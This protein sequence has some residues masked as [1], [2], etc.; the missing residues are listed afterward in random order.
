MTESLGCRIELVSPADD[1]A[2]VVFSGHGGTIRVCRAATD[3]AGHLRLSSD[4]VPVGDRREPLVAPNGTVIELVSA[5]T[6]IVLPDNEPSLSIVRSSPDDAFGSGRAGM[7]YRDLLPDRW[8]GRFI[9]SHIR[10][11]EGGDVADYVHF[12][13]IRFQMIFVASGWVDV[14]YEDQGPPFRLHRGDCVLQ[15]PEIR[16]RV[17]RSSPGLE[18]IE[19]GC[20]ARHDTVA[21]HSIELP[22]PSA[23]TRPG[24]RWSTLRSPCCR[25]H[26]S[27]RCRDPGLHRSRHGH[28]TRD[29]SSGRRTGVGRGDRFG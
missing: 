29:G 2:E 11:A 17:L 15:P 13:R 24:L 4:R 7:G 16:H 26:R 14:V 8:G 28:R 27:G 6:A 21:E 22:T 5:S 20:P 23:C 19:I 18:V 12:H 1:P 3:V 9:A 25:R 10:I